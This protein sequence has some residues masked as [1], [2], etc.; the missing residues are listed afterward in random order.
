[1]ARKLIR[2]WNHLTATLARKAHRPVQWVLTR[3]EV[4]LDGSLSGRHR[5]DQN[6]GQEGRP[7]L[8]RQV[9]AA[10]DIG[11]YALTSTNTG[12]TAVKYLGGRIG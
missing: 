4:F 2:V 6:R 5:A 9:E 1:M 3:E 10:Y 12:R 8:A 7:N 11:A